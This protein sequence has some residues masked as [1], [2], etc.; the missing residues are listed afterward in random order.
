M[1]QQIK[2]IMTDNRSDESEVEREALRKFT[3]VTTNFLRHLTLVE[4][5]PNALVMG[6][7]MLL[8]IHFLNSY[9]NFFFQQTCEL[10]VMSMGKQ[11]QEGK[12]SP[13][14]LADC[15]WT[16]VGGAPE[17]KKSVNHL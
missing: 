12:W 11:Y 5:L 14:M 8:K 4:E 1:G 17:K 15:C 7:E 13:S 3:G 10:L 9:A 6:S 2:E 16:L